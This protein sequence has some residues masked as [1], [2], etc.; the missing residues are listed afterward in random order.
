[1]FQE[2]LQ[3]DITMG[4]LEMLGIQVGEEEEHRIGIM[5]PGKE[6]L[7]GTRKKQVIF[8][9]GIPRVMEETGNQVLMV[10]MAGMLE[11]QE[12]HVPQ[13]Q[14]NTVRKGTHGSGQRKVM[15]CHTEIEEIGANAI[16][17][18]ISLLLRGHWILLHRNNQKA[19]L[20]EP[21]EKV[22][23]LPEIKHIAGLPTH[24]RKLQ[25][26]NQGLKIMFLKPQIKWILYLLLLLIHQ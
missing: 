22:S 7:L 15:F 1:M 20:Q 2:A 19:K 3:V 14:V 26:S 9:A 21:V 10:Q 12:I 16:L 5:V 8:L 25:S 11:A 24:P 4:I 6:I 23:V 18:G 13:N 17:P